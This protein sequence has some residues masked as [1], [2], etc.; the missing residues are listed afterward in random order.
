MYDI[1][2]GGDSITGKD[3]DLLLDEEGAGYTLAHEWG[4]YAYGLGD[5]YKIESSDVAVVPSI[6][7]DQW[8]ARGGGT[9]WLNF[10][11]PF[12]SDPPGPFQ[13]TRKTDQHRLYEESGWETLARGE[14]LVEA[15]V[16]ALPG[17]LERPVY[18]EL[19]TVAPQG[20][21]Q[22]SFPDIPGEARKFLEIVWAEDPG[23]GERFVRF[24]EGFLGLFAA[25]SIPMQI[26]STMNQL[27]V[28]VGYTGTPTDVVLELASPDGVRYSPSGVRDSGGETRAFFSV[29]NPTLGRW[30][31]HADGSVTIGYQAAARADGPT[32]TL[33]AQSL[34]GSTIQY[35]KPIAIV[36][37]LG[38]ELPIVG[39]VCTG[40]M[41]AP[42]G[43]QSS[44]QFSDDGM[45]SDAIAND[46]LYTAVLDYNQNGTFD[47]R[48]ECDNSRGTA[49]LSAS[50]LALTADIHGN[51]VP[52]PPDIVIGE[53][54]QRFAIVQVV[55]EGVVS[56]DH[57]NTPERA[58]AIA[59]D[60]AT[61]VPGKIETPGDVDVFAL[62]VPDGASAVVVRVSGLALGM[63]PKLRILASDG[64]TVLREGTRATNSS[65]RGYLFLEVGAPGGEKL[66]AEVS[67]TDART[68][69]GTYLVSAGAALQF[70]SPLTNV[71]PIDIE[72]GEFPNRITISRDPNRIEVTTVAILTTPTF[73]ATTV[74][75]N[76]V[77]FGKTGTE[78]A[79]VQAA[80]ADADGDGTL[81]LIL[82]FRTQDTG[83]QCGDTSALLTG[84]TV[85]G[86]AIQGS[87]S[88]VTVRGGVICP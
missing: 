35:P 3:V 71:V 2:A 57:G 84:K 27:V 22:P 42:D 36:A 1:F 83:L 82:R 30:Q 44:I 85:S 87:D 32:Y 73:N 31:L 28:S 24:L 16:A 33:A 56:D 8:S 29:D 7:N 50:G 75:S 23:L 17:K 25:E 80:V 40:R 51:F 6:M 55:T 61:L 37:I 4:H 54:F 60:N 70:D 68:G 10:S 14:T 15:L 58:T 63:E 12:Q 34:S 11:I 66:F 88:I 76:T 52:P 62:Q 53:N 46:G 5:E 9:E 41:T 86:Q 64:I 43:T 20:T 39:A 19:R 21:N 78:A 26:D 67:H 18:P 77:R 74:D 49:A 79:P 38:K 69:T 72:P 65:A 47:I 13:N 81:D 59:A 48:V 45:G